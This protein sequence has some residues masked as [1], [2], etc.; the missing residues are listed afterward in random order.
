MTIFACGCPLNGPSFY[1]V[2]GTP[3]VPLFSGIPP[4]K[5]T[6][7]LILTLILSLYPLGHHTPG[8]QRKT[9]T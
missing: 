2:P 8:Y 7:Y 4:A 5:Q 6:R 9:R 3:A 1:G